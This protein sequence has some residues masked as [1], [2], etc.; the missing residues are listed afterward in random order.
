MEPQDAMT[1]IENALNMGA[2]KGVFNLKDSAT[3]F[4]SLLKV[5]SIVDSHGM[6]KSIPMQTE[7][8]AESK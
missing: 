6:A 7:A 3:I 4:A 5:K 2:Q 1:I 8:P